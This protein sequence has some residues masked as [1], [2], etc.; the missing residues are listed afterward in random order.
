MHMN[1]SSYTQMNESWH[2]YMNVSC[3]SHMKKSSRTHM[4]ESWHT[5]THTHVCI[6]WYGVDFPEIQFRV[7]RFHNIYGPHGT[8][9]GGREKVRLCCSMLQCIVGGVLSQHIC[10]VLSQHIGGVLSQD[11][12][13]IPGFHQVQ[14][15]VV[16]QHICCEA[17]WYLLRWQIHVL[18]CWCEYLQK[19]ISIHVY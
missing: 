18:M 19:D 11:I 2:T 9:C 12:L 6:R 5:R 8:W 3:H 13:H 7:V 15:G 17:L 14:G 4:N 1:E 16:S 10:G